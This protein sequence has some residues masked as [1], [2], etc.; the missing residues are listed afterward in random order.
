MRESHGFEVKK[1]T[2]SFFK[3][4]RLF[5]NALVHKIKQEEYREIDCPANQYI[6]DQILTFAPVVGA[7]LPAFLAESL[8]V[9]VL[10]RD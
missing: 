2:T 5:R 4:G 3:K 9:L 10:F 8:T 1:Q 6:V 7:D